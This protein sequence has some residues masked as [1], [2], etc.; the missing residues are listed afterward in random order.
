MKN[1]LLPLLLLLSCGTSKTT[2]GGSTTPVIIDADTVRIVIHD[3][4]QAAPV[5]DTVTKV[6]HDTAYVFATP[7]TVTMIKDSVRIRDSVV[8]I[9]QVSIRDSIITHAVQVQGFMPIA[10]TATVVADGD[11]SYVTQD[12]LTG[13]LWLRTNRGDNW[14]QMQGAINYSFDNPGITDHY[15]PGGYQYS[16]P[17]IVGRLIGNQYAQ[18]SIDMEGP[19]SAKN[20]I[21]AYCAIFEPQYTNAPLLILQNCKGCTINKIAFQGQYNLPHYLNPVQVDT[22]DWDGWSDGKCTDGRTDA[23][24]AI[25]I[26]AFCDSDYFKGQ[27]YPLRMVTGLAKWY[28]AG[29]GRG[30][31][32]GIQITNCGFTDVVASVVEG[33]SFQENCELVN[34]IDCGIGYSR[35]GVCVSQAQSKENHVIRLKL[36]NNIKKAFDGVDFGFWRGDGSTMPMIDGVNVA[37]IVYE[38]IDGD[39]Y[40]FPVSINQVYGEGLFKFGRIA[41]NAGA[42]MTNFQVDFGTVSRSGLP[43]PDF[44]AD[45]NACTWSSDMLRTYDQYGNRAIV[46]N[47]PFNSFDGGSMSAPPVTYP[48]STPLFNVMDYYKGTLIRGPLDS[49]YQV[50]HSNFVH[51]SPGF[52]GLFTTSTPGSFSPN[53]LLLTYNTNDDGGIDYLLSPKD[54]DQYPLGFVYAVS[55]DTVFF[56]NSPKGIRDGMQLPIFIPI[57]TIAR[58]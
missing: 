11:T 30:G 10:T 54:N 29:A 34:V 33:G 31:S 40:T 35:A 15:L 26:D 17:L 46:L 18:V 56:E 20:A 12:L 9:Y 25:D 43:S 41:G 8:P 24:V 32:T 28:P 52:I 44:W 21:G 22:L 51:M 27:V 37:G 58:R 23:H 4:T 14:A 49:V 57:S 6:E 13:D 16:K 1:L 5:H 42:H 39:A 2:I 47:S 50:D 36:W 7:D 48:Y 3:T 53:Q 55:S 19:W 38:L 45:C